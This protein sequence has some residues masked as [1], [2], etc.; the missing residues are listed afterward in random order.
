MSHDAGITKCKTEI[1]NDKIQQ[2]NEIIN[3][4]KEQVKIMAKPNDYN[5]RVDWLRRIDFER[6]K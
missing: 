5:D 3:V 1:K 2:Q 4:K 6:S